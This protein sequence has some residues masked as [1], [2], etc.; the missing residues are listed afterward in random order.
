VIAVRVDFRTA[1]FS[2]GSAFDAQ[3]VRALF[4]CGPC[5]G[6]FGEGCDAIAFFDAQFRGVANLNSLLGVG[7]SAA[8]IGNSSMTKN[9][10]A[11]DYAALSDAPFTARSPR[12]SPC[13]L[14]TESI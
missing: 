8:S 11:F 1:Q 10:L 3:A 14:R 13:A 6:I 4:Y 12:F 7:P 2:C 9:L 5:S